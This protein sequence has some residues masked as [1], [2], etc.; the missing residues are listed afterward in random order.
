MRVHI[1]SRHGS[2]SSTIIEEQGRDQDK[3][4]GDKYE[5]EDKIKTRIR[6]IRMGCGIKYGSGKSGKW[7]SDAEG[8]AKIT[9]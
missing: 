6:R 3:D 5:D 9:T 8:A 4:T 2:D 1:Y 7:R